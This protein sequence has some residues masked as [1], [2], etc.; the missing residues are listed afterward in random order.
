MDAHTPL[1]TYFDLVDLRLFVRI[2][3]ANSLTRGAEN[4]CLSISAASQRIKNIEEAIGSKLL[5]RTKRGVSATE[6][7]DV[8]L[9][10]ARSML[11]QMGRLQVDMQAFTLGVRGH[12]RVF[13]NSLATTE[14]LPEA[15]GRFLATHET[16]TV[17]LQERLST[18]V[19]RAVHEGVADVGVLTATVRAHGLETLPYRNHRLVLAVPLE[20]RLAAVPFIHFV[21][22]LDEAFVG[23]SPHSAITSLLQRE[24]AA[25]GRGMR[26][27]IQVGSFDAM[28]RMIESN[29]GI[30]VLP[31]A[32]ALR[33]ARM[34]RIKLVHLLDEWAEREVR[35]CVRRLDELPVFA[36][37]LVDFLL[38]N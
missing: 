6:A 35:I 19:V 23:M 17:D 11:G 36:R 32:P 34:S 4:S 28:C 37:E 31:E 24:V 10:H 20:H 1:V 30:G 21:D 3:E 9:N 14:L 29:V 13:A 26:M 2:V 25:L 16:T 5:I 18:E 8:F 22:V 7:G 15:L 33:H 27:R 38:H 12:V